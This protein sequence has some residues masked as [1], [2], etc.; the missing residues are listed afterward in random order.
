VGRR[1]DVWRRGRRGKRGRSLI[2][3]LSCRVLFISCRLLLHISFLPCHCRKIGARGQTERQR[4]R[5]A[6]AV[7]TLA[8]QLMTL[9]WQLMEVLVL[10]R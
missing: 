2:L 8:W 7:R 10:V 6:V 1:E 5:G 9:V 4:G 3:L